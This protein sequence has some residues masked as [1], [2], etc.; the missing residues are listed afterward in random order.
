MSE[1]IER[2]LTE[3]IL[4]RLRCQ[5]VRSAK[6]VFPTK[7]PRP[8]GQVHLDVISQ[9]RR[10]ARPI[11]N[12]FP[13]LRGRSHDLIVF[14]V[15][16]VGRRKTA[17]ADIGCS[18]EVRILHARGDR[19][20]LGVGIIDNIDSSAGRDT[21]V[22]QIGRAGIDELVRLRTG[23]RR[24]GTVVSPKR[25]SPSPDTTKNSSSWTKAGNR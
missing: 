22:A 12:G 15:V 4:R 14:V 23:W 21:E 7:Y 1:P 19:D 24:I 9:T 16:I 2:S 25:Y 13:L 8:C 6:A 17:Q 3:N 18:L 20:L 10:S 5:H 11:Q